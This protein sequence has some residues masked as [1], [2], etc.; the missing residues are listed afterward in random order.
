MLR[1]KACLKG[2][3][4]KQ[5]KLLT[6]FIFSAYYPDVPMLEVP[7]T[8]PSS[9]MSGWIKKHSPVMPA[10]ETEA[11]MQKLMNEYDMK[12]PDD[13]HEVGTN[14]LHSAYQNI[15]T[16]LYPRDSVKGSKLFN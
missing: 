13:S 6:K 12:C 1:N 4:L 3:I 16:C 9:S 11:V 2:K 10:K 15:R 7:Q 14:S 5:L 8:R